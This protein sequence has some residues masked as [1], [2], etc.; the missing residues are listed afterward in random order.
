[1]KV[2]RMKDIYLI[3]ILVV[4]ALIATNFMTEDKDLIWCLAFDRI[5]FGSM[6]IAVFVLVLAVITKIRED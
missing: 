3:A 5:L 2:I 6:A 1:M 4:V